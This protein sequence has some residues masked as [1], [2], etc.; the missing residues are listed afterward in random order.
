[1]ADLEELSVTVDP[2][3][4]GDNDKFKLA[5]VISQ[6]VSRSGT[7]LLHFFEAAFFVL[8]A[9]GIGAPNV[10]PIHI[11]CTSP[12][13]KFSQKTTVFTLIIICSP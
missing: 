1:M 5:T 9:A 7:P 10:E 6:K 12:Y 11:T 4:G 13:I 3:A 8:S 2:L